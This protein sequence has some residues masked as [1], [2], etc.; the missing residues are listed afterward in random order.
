MPQIQLPIFP[1]GVTH[2]TSELAFKKEGDRVIYF[3]GQMPVFIH[4]VNDLKTFRMITSQFCVSG[5]ARVS[6]I[7]KAFGIPLVSVKRAVKKYR[8]RGPQGFYAARN[9]RKGGT[10]LTPEV[11]VKAQNYLDE[12]LSVR[13]IST[14][15]EIKY[16]T[17]K[18]A[19]TDGRLKKKQVR[20]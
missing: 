16:E 17:V 14:K 20:K 8:E 5:N 4:D 13:E 10:I 18:K 1:S 6:E 15:F 12:G 3:N 19:V 9:K 7:A 11:L 2:I